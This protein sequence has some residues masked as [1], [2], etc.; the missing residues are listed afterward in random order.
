[1]PAPPTTVRTAKAIRMIVTSTPK[2]G[3]PPARHA[4]H[5]AVLEAPTE[6]RA[7]AERQLVAGAGLGVAGRGAGRG[8]GLAVGVLRVHGVGVHGSTVAPQGG[9]AHR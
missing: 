1:M 3:G 7:G 5:H 9:S 8:V 2:W 6:G 4:G